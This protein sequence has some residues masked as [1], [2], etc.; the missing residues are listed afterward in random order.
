[1]SG[2]KGITVAEAAML[3]SVKPSTVRSWIN[4]GHIQRGRRGL[5]DPVELL[6]W[7]NRRDAKMVAVRAG[8]QGSSTR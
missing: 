4:R 3:C 2:L 6:A 8:A 7:W 5:I 1:M